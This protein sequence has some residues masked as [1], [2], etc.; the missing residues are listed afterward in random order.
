VERFPLAAGSTHRRHSSRA[1]V[2]K[3]TQETPHAEVA[4]DI[5]LRTRASPNTRQPLL[6]G[7]EHIITEGRRVD[8]DHL[9]RAQ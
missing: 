9:A 1:Q 6:H 4:T 2:R 3:I 5:G 8:D 7:V